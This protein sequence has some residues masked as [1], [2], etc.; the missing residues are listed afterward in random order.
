V[1]R[2]F[3]PAFHD[4]DIDTDTDILQYASGDNV[5]ADSAGAVFYTRRLT[6]QITRFSRLQLAFSSFLCFPLFIMSK[7]QLSVSLLVIKKL[8]TCL[9]K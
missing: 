5:Q 4:T 2:R 9:C 7:L 6:N 3:K 8:I 1:V